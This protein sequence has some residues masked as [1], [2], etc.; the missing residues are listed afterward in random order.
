MYVSY[1]NHIYFVR[2]KM[3]KLPCVR[4]DD[5]SQELRAASVGRCEHWLMEYNNFPPDVWISACTF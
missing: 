5:P 2:V 3:V 4:E 1:K